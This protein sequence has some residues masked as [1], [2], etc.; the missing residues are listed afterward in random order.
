[1]KECKEHKFEVKLLQGTY[2]WELRNSLINDDRSYQLKQNVSDIA[3]AFLDLDSDMSPTLDDILSMIE[4]K[5]DVICLPY[6]IHRSPNVYQCGTFKEGIP[7]F[8]EKRFDSSETGLKKIPW[9]G[10]GCRLT[11][12]HVYNA[13][14][15]PWY[16]HP[17]VKVNGSQKE[18]GE[19]I[20]FSMGVTKSGYDIWC[21][22]DR[23]VKHR[24][25]SVKDFNWEF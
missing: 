13:M 10:N 15:Y 9:S 2:I 11:M 12:A 21:D 25:R 8:V 4:K 3:D 6:L 14:E 17:M 20:G 18:A 24:S 16:R 23:P 5:K 19:D 22:F 1:M 7:G